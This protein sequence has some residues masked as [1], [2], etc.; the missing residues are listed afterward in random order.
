[1]KPWRDSRGY[2]HGVAHVRVYRVPLG[3][4]LLGPTAGRITEWTNVNCRLS[5]DRKDSITVIVLI[6]FVCGDVMHAYSNEHNIRNDLRTMLWLCLRLHL[7]LRLS[8]HLRLL[9]RWREPVGRG[10]TALGWTHRVA[11]VVLRRWVRCCRHFVSFDGTNFSTD[12]LLFKLIVTSINDIRFWITPCSSSMYFARQQQ[13][14]FICNNPIN[15]CAK[16]CFLMSVYCSGT[17]YVT[18]YQYVWT[19]Q[20]TYMCSTCRSAALIISQNIHALRV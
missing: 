2:A 16:T 18:D 8:L 3:T 6:Y 11:L 20:C 19:N 15:V 17:N 10:L 5:S 1:M 12:D 7:H 4:T 14:L 9:W 13:L